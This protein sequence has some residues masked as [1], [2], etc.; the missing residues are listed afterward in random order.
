MVMYAQ[1]ARDPTYTVVI[2]GK[3]IGQVVRPVDL[4]VFGRTQGTVYL[5][6]PVRKRQRPAQGGAATH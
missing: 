4:R 5:A 2:D 3:K 1:D 6:R